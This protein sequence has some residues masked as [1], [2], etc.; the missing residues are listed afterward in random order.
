MLPRPVTG[1]KTLKHRNIPFTSTPILGNTKI[2]ILFN[3]K[4]YND[5]IIYVYI[6]DMF[7][8]EGKPLEIANMEENIG[9]NLFTDYYSFTAA[10]P[11]EWING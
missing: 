1:T 5:K 6:T 9:M 2:N 4:W 10:L 11:N 3:K 7:D 8:N